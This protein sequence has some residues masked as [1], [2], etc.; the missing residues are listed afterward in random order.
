VTIHLGPP[1]QAVRVLGVQ[2]R[3]LRLIQRELP[4]KITARGGILL[5]QG[6]P[7]H[8]QQAG[9]IFEELSSLPGPG[10]LE[11]GEVASI[12]ERVRA[13]NGQAPQPVPAGREDPLIPALRRRVIARSPGQ[14]AYLRALREND[15]CL[16]TGPAGTGKTYLAVY[17]ALGALLKGEVRRLV[18]VRPAV[19]AGERLGFLPGDLREK[20]DPYLRPLYDALQ[21][22]AGPERLRQWLDSGTVEIAPL[23]YMRG[24]TLEDA[25]ILLDEAQNATPDQMKMFL[26]RLGLRSRAAVT[27]DLT[28]V[29]LPPGAASGMADAVSRLEG[30]PGIAVV[31]L[32]A[33]DVVRHPLVR[34]I[35]KAYQKRSRKS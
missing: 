5:V 19:E 31:E 1:E 33:A 26:T 34:D 12:V 28:Q 14:E 20:V 16:A 11:P 21:D 13:R 24:R 9:R 3:N 27:G 6:A 29:D 2:D 15:L 25:Y 7:E 4:V 10:V 23:A 22:L 30:I 35:L 8:V 18:L 17:T 32:T